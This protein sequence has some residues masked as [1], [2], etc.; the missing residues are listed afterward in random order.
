MWILRFYSP[1]DD[2][3]KLEVPLPGFDREDALSSLGCLP[4]RYGSTE[5]KASDVRALQDLY[6]F[7]VPKGLMG[8]LD[9]DAP[10]APAERFKSRRSRIV[11]AR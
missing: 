8:Y 10:A 5:L 4:T 2:E 3:M 9:Y 7:K 11:T 6:G 1:T